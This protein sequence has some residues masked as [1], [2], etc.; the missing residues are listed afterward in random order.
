MI[1]RARINESRTLYEL[2]RFVKNSAQSFSIV[3]QTKSVFLR[4]LCDLCF[5]IFVVR[6][7]NSF[8]FVLINNSAV[9]VLSAH[10]AFDV[11]SE[12]TAHGAL[13]NAAHDARFLAGA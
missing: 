8:Q 6:W 7:P 13:G 2:R 12:L 4:K 9:R 1:C 3:S 11:S 5:P 10:F